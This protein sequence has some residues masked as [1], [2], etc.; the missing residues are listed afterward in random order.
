M[1]IDYEDVRL[2]PQSKPYYRLGDG[3]ASS[4]EFRDIWKDSDLPRV[5]GRIA[6]AAAGRYKRLEKHPEKTDSKIRM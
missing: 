5:I 1:A 6:E 4:E 2:T 3:V